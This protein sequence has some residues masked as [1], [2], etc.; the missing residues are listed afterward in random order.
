V[1]PML[2]Y[3]KNLRTSCSGSGNEAR[4]KLSG[5]GLKSFTYVMQSGASTLALAYQ[6][7]VPH[8]PT[9][10]LTDGSLSSMPNDHLLYLHLLKRS[11]PLPGQILSNGTSS[12]SHS[13]VNHRLWSAL[14]VN[15]EFPVG[16]M[17]AHIL[18]YCPGVKYKCHRY[19]RMLLKVSPTLRSTSQRNW[20]SRF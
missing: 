12:R 11:W 8:L 17:G 5:F 2:L 20:P 10:Y 6:H 9:G 4:H 14:N 13:Y 1:R 15:G 16:E 3:F 18:M 7:L 19:G